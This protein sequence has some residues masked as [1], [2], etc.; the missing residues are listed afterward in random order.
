MAN[1]KLAEKVFDQMFLDVAFFVK[2]ALF[3]GQGLLAAEVLGGGSSCIVK[4]LRTSEVK[5]RKLQEKD[6]RLKKVHTN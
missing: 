5:I 1:T 4:G 3:L 6:L 2:I